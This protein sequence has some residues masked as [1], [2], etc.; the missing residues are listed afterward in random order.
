[1]LKLGNQYTKISSICLN[2]RVAEVQ[3][4]LINK[5]IAFAAHQFAFQTNLGHSKNYVHKNGH[6]RLAI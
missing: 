5:F 1:M 4:L 2:I 3:S 6:Y